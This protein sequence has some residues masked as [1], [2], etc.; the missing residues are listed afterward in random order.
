MHGKEGQ[1]ETEAEPGEMHLQGKECEGPRCRQRPGGRKEARPP[2]SPPSPEPAVGG[3]AL[4]TPPEPAAG[5]AAPMAP[6]ACSG[7]RGSDDPA[8]SAFQPP[9]LRGNTFRLL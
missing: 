7:G 1:R 8:L 9:G 4:M 5:G 2:P 3:A 6:G